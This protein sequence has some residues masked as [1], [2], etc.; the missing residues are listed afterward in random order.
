MTVTTEEAAALVDVS[1]VTIRRWVQKGWLV[2][3]P[4]LDP[5]RRHHLFETEAV[6]ACERA[7]RSG[8]RRAAVAR[9]LRMWGKS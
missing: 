9:A 5:A 1:P 2:P 6:I 3:V 8:K 7:H 4:V